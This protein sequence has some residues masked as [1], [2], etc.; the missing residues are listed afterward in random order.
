MHRSDNRTNSNSVGE[1]DLAMKGKG[2]FL[3][4]QTGVLS[5]D[6]DL[7]VIPCRASVDSPIMPWY[8]LS[9]SPGRSWRT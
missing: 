4:G 2:N 1:C 5:D 6:C 7:E 9:V 8:W 3:A